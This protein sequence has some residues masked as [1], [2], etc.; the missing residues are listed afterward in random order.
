MTL[1]SA[2]A[3]APDPV[4]K[5]VRRVLLGGAD[6]HVL[7]A[8]H[9]LQALVLELLGEVVGLAVG[10]ELDPH[11]ELGQPVALGGLFVLG[12]HQPPVLG[13]LL[14]RGRRLGASGAS[15]S[16]A[17]SCQCRS[18]NLASQPSGRAALH[19]PLRPIQLLPIAAYR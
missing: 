12:P 4:G 1:L 5:L 9:R 3:S 11:L 19:H 18:S 6:H 17:T 7:P 16:S 13:L 2:G 14:G 8:P 15:Q 10:G